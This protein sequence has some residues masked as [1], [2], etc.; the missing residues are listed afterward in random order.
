M[1]FEL[2]YPFGID[3]MKNN[4]A[5]LLFCPPDGLDWEGRPV[6]EGRSI[7]FSVP[8]TDYRQ[9]PYPDSRG[10]S[11]RA[12]NVASLQSLMKNQAGIRSLI[13][14]I[15][16]YLHDEKIIHPQTSAAEKIY[17][18][19][20][21]GYKAPQIFFMRQVLGSC[22]DIPVICSIMSRF[23]H[24]I[25]NVL[26]LMILDNDSEFPADFEISERIYRYADSKGHLIGR[27]ESCAASKSTI[28]KYIEMIE[29]AD[30][31]IFFEEGI[32]EQAKEDR[33]LS[34]KDTE[35]ICH[36]ARMVA[37]LELGALI[38]ETV[39]CKFWRNFNKS[40]LDDG[41]VQKF[42]TT[43]CL[44]AKKISLESNPFEHPLFKRAHKLTESMLINKKTIDA[45]L[46]VA[47]K[48]TNP[49]AEDAYCNTKKRMVLKK[50]LASLFSRH[51]QFLMTQLSSDGLFLSVDIDNFFGRWPNMNTPDMAIL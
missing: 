49:Y 3:L 14:G 26:S 51:T 15:A 17:A 39:R 6:L 48:I 16:T 2:P 50:L 46:S 9:C 41:L 33:G 22:Q 25:V 13:T 5:F 18:I 11:K 30:L 38:Y 36:A 12:M 42:A 37:E 32:K 40:N 7:R 24:G 20:Y 44:V 43:H 34:C 10:K 23:S 45:M 35:M 29:N 27:R 8:S 21:I 31:N 4:H 1:K 19:A 28:I 47:R